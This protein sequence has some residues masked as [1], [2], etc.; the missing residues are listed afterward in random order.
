[1]GAV[2]AGRRTESSFPV[3]LASTNPSSTME[4]TALNDPQ[5]GQTSGYDP[6]VNAAISH[7]ALVTA[8][9]VQV[10]YDGNINLD[11]LKGVHEYPSAESPPTFVGGSEGLT[12]DRVTIVSGR[13]FN[14]RSA[15]EAVMNVE[16][17]RELG[18]HV[19]SVIGIPVYTD[20]QIRVIQ[21]S[22][23]LTVSP[24]R[25]VNV[26]LVGVIVL[27][28]NVV[29]DDIDA[30]GASTVLFS[31]ALN[32]QL[33]SCCAYYTGVA[34]QIKSG[35]GNAGRVQRE[36]EQ[37]DP[38][39]KLGIAGGSSVATVTEQAHRA[40]EPE[41]AALEIFGAIA[42]LA[43]LLIAGLAIGRLLHNGSSEMDVL[44][45]L[46]AS[47]AM[48][49]GDGLVGIVA[50]VAAGALVAGVVAFLLSP[51]APLGPVRP[52]YPYR[53]FNADWTVL[54]L[55]FAGLIFILGAIGLWLSVRELRQL[56]SRGRDAA[57]RLQPR[58][59][60]MTPLRHLPISMATGLR[61]AI[62]P[63]RGR[64]TAPMRS[65]MLGTAITVIVLVTTVTFG[66]SLNNL[67]SHPPLYG[68]NWNYALLSGFAGAEDL[69]GPQ[70]AAY[71]NHDATIQAWSG[72]SFV[73]A[74]LDGEQ[75]QTMDENPGAK[76]APP[77]LS[78]HG[79]ESAN[80]VVLG[81]TTLAQLH[82]R[83]GDTVIFNNGKTAPK[84]LIIVGTATMTPVSSGLE[85]GSGALVATADFPNSLLNSQQSPIPGPQDVLIRVRPGTDPRAAR[86]SLNRI[87]KE[88]NQLPKGGQQAGGVVAV[89]RP[90]EIVNYRSMGTAPALLSGGLVVGAVL[91]L[92]LTLVASVRRRRRDLALLKT[93]G[94]VR[95]QLAS[96]VAWQA[97]T[98]VSIGTLVAV[99]VGIVLGRTLWDLFAREIH[100]VPAPSVPALTIVLTVVG[101]LIL[102]IAVAVIPGLMAASTPTALVLREE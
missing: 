96:A 71:L 5:L 90:A 65:A 4:F 30:L 102:A 9:A 8:T 59:E 94:F 10:G 97:G 66:A 58:V 75:V 93:L 14:V 17:E 28:N 3:Y 98:A 84:R 101:A 74:T 36:V 72:V 80:E 42:G 21:K 81:A 34:L 2:A 86:E 79:L 48:T 27:N 88:I 57:Q 92:G 18:V 55:G 22:G 89:L 23:N 99:P 13:M 16:A 68:W 1:M 39:T 85:M 69:P 78:G 47:R 91:A 19:G 7:L 73:G 35:R 95:R 44:R 51:F 53:G 43:A 38:L 54:G 77:V 25:V 24:Y 52:V 67:V 26:T 6:R 41:A 60:R 29:Q 64:N 15:D 100:A 40:I 70:T 61:F 62:E 33:Q 31:P 46:G 20:A 63:S 50:S 49:L 45:A 76:V 82:K 32:A 37:V 12:M 83:V 11:S 87:V 56:S